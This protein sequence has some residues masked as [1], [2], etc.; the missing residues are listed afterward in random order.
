MMNETLSKKVVRHYGIRLPALLAFPIS[1]IVLYGAAPSGWKEGLGALAMVYILPGFAFGALLA[2][3]LLNQFIILLNFRSKSAC[4]FAGLIA[5]I[6]GT[7]LAVMALR[8]LFPGR[9]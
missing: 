9:Y 6:P 4:L 7:G 2:T 1:C 3:A 5:V 8:L